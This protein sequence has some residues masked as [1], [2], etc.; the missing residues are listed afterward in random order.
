MVIKRV[1]PVS[2]AKIAGL[3][4]ALI[5]FPSA[6]LFWIA[7]LVGLSSY[8]LSGSPFGPGPALMA[9]AGAAAV[10]TLP[11]IYGVIGFLMTLIGAWL[12]NLMAALVGGIDVEIQTETVAE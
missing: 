9:G 10:V 3:I 1:A 7:S 5:G 6:I 8:G 12:Y 4:Y 2:A 11:I